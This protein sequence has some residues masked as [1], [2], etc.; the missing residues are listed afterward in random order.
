MIE[1]N[2]L[3]RVIVDGILETDQ[4]GQRYLPGFSHPISDL[5]ANTMVEYKEKNYPLEAI[6]NFWKLLMLNIDKKIRETLFTFLTHYKFAITDNGYFVAYK[7]V[8]LFSEGIADED[9]SKFVTERFAK[10]KSWKKSPKNYSVL[11]TNEEGRF[12]FI[13]V[14]SDE[15]ELHEQYESV[16]NLDELNTA[17][18]NGS[19]KQTVYTDKWNGTTR[20][21]LGTPVRKT[22]RVEAHEV[23]CSDNG[24][25]AGSTPYVEG[26]YNKGN[27]VLMVLINPAHVIHVPTSDSTKLRTAEY[28]PYA[29][30]E[31]RDDLLVQQSSNTFNFTVLDQ[32]Y[33][34]T[35]Y[36]A[37][38][39]TK[40][41]EDLELIRQEEQ[42]KVPKTERDIDYKKILETR[43]VDLTTILNK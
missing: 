8:K 41:E 6:T 25:H 1:L 4:T 39:K 5:L 18:Q 9:F 16:G 27:Y 42:N 38:E 15:Q 2:R 23:E 35:D 22:R 30:L 40:I 7:V 13:T 21:M 3:N 28:Y 31:K 26:Y 32:P 43:L 37:Y 34:E 29:L 17:I 33:F 19:L 11:R 20:I 24:L 14:L 36:A 12:K 10:L